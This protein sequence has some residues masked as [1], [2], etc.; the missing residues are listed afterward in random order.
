MLLSLLIL[1][2]GIQFIRPAKNR[3]AVR[4]TA[5]LT[6]VVTVPKPVLNKLRTA[7]FD[8]HSNDT[9][10]PWYAHVAPVSWWI[11][12]HIKKGKQHLNFSRFADYSK[13]R[14]LEKLDKVAEAIQQ[15]WMPLKSYKLL[16]ADAVLKPEEVKEISNWLKVAEADLEARP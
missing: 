7:C 2:L 13:K 8:C 4:S 10:Y 5:D 16:H 1:F 12:G 3:T 11:A 6:T 9:R 15:G 14:Q